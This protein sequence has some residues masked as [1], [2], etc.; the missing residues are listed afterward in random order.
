MKRGKGNILSFYDQMSYI[1]ILCLEPQPFDL[2][3]VTIRMQLNFNHRSWD[4][5]R[6]ISK[7][8][9]FICIVIS[10]VN[11]NIEFQSYHEITKYNK[12]QMDIYNVYI[13]RCTF[14]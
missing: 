6:N 11:S 7:Q 3:N 13:E 14:P 2:Q 1:C 12:N 9:R 8:N 4:L 10:R 5:Y